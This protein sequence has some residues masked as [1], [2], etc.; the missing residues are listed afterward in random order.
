MQIT[1]I[2]PAAGSV[3]IWSPTTKDDKKTFTFDSV[4]DLDS[5]QV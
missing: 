3:A 4:F 5:I 1:D 2:S